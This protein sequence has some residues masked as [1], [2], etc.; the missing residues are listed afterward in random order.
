[1]TSKEFWNSTPKEFHFR[2]KGYF[3]KMERLN[4]E[5]WKRTRWQVFRMKTTSK[6]ETKKGELSIY[7]IVI[8]P[9]EKIQVE[10]KNKIDPIA[11]KRMA[12]AMDQHAKNPN[13]NSKTVTP[14]ELLNQ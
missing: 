1:M 3:K 13:H 14:E 4:Q 12:A 6:A 9:W 2:Q 11:L 8:F 5:D 10:A 7:D